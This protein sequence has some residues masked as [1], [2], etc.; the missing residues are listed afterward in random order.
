[1]ICVTYDMNGQTV[2]D[3]YIGGHAYVDLGLPS[4]TL[5][6]VYNVGSDDEYYVGDYFAWGETEPKEL[7]IWENYLYFKDYTGAPDYTVDLED[8][9]KCISGTEYDAAAVN[10]GNGWMMPDSVQIAEI[11][12]HTF[13]KRVEENGIGGM[14]VYSRKFGGEKSIFLGDFGHGYSDSSELLFYGLYWSGTASETNFNGEHSPLNANSFE[15]QRYQGEVTWNG[16]I[17]R[18][19][20]LCVRPVIRKTASS[21]GTHCSDLKDYSISVSDGS[22]I[23]N[24]EIMNG[25]LELTYLS[26][27]M[28]SSMEITDSRCGLPNLA[29]GV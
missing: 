26:G 6:A 23:I 2:P 1:M 3:G 5:W 28:S 19:A 24:G 16:S 22:V 20:G 9:G 14:R 17:A 25:R 13:S 21:I 10:W 11:R 4:G 8:I 12:R 15:C 29:P 18:F 7:Y 27:H